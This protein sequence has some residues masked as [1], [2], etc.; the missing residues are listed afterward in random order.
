MSIYLINLDS[1]TV[2]GVFGAS[3]DAEIAGEVAGFSYYVG[4]A[5]DLLKFTGKEL[6]ALMASVGDAYAANIS[7][8][9]RIERIMHAATSFAFAPP[10]APKAEKKAKTPKK[11]KKAKAPGLKAQLAARLEAGETVRREEYPELK[12]SS[13]LTALSD[14]K[15]AKYCGR[16]EG[17]LNI[18][19]VE[20]GA[21]SCVSEG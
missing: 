11:A 8:A 14:L 17:P 18:K 3:T 6:R 4:D 15:S 19:R 9:D 7:K 21:Y 5:D 10:P 12:E 1:M 2:A 13:F 20:K 16:A